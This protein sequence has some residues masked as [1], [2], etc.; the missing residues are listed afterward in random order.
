MGTSRK[1]LST[2]VE[3]RSLYQPT[4]LRWG[5]GAVLKVHDPINSR[6]IW[7]GSITESPSRLVPLLTHLTR[8]TA[9]YKLYQFSK[10]RDAIY[11]VSTDDGA[12]T[13]NTQTWRSI[14]CKMIENWYKTSSSRLES[15]LRPR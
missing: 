12:Q 14:C 15:T 5:S 7:D 13:W 3:W 10:S 1:V 6:S 2:L 9:G 8:L 11:R 4:R